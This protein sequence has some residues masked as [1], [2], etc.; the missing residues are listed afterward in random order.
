VAVHAVN[1][2]GSSRSNQLNELAT[3][4]WHYAIKR[5]VFLR[6][7]YVPG[8]LNTEADRASR[9]FQDVSDWRLHPKV[10]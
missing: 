10:F 5:N 3:E 4:L 8:K 2:F 6:A 1:G 9:Y 7:V